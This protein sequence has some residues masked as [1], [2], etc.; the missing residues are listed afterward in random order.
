MTTLDLAPR[1]AAV[2]APARR[3]TVLGGAALIVVS[4]P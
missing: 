4:I 3:L 2:S 1:A